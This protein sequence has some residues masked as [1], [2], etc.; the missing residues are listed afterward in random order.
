VQNDWHVGA[1][2]VEE[3]DANGRPTVL[4]WTN[5]AGVSW[6][7]FADS[8][9][10]ILRTGEENPYYETNPDGGRFFRIVL[11]RNAEGEY[12]PEPAGFLFQSGF[13]ALEK[14]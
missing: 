4:R 11:R 14:P 1:I 10:G 2:T 9:N 6:R 7:L 3:R 12:R 5:Q 13:Y 8:A